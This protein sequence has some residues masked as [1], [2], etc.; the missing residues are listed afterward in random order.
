[1]EEPRKQLKLFQELKDES[2]HLV[3]DTIEDLES[4]AEIFDINPNTNYQLIKLYLENKNNDNFTTFYLNKIQTLC[5]DQKK[6]IIEKINQD[7]NKEIKT[8]ILNW[9]NI[10]DKSFFKSYFLILKELLNILMQC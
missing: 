5:F 3:N 2:I 10:N 7:E 8:G 1:M 4:K 6:E 9:I